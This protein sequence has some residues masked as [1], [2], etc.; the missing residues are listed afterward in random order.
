MLSLEQNERLAHVGP[1]TPMGILMRR[2]WHLVAAT[3]QLENHPVKEVTLLGESLVLFRDLRGRLGL[4]AE[5]CPHRGA[6]LA[7]GIIED[8]GLRC[9]YHGWLYDARGRCLDQPLEPPGDASKDGIT[10]VAYPVQELAGL[11]FAYLG[12][13]PVPLLPRYNVLAW[14]N[15]ARQTEGCLIPCNWLQVM[16]NLMDPMHVE[17]LHRHY[18]AYVL[19]RQGGPRLQEFLAHYAPAPMKKFGFDLFEHGIIERHV[20]GTEGDYSWKTGTPTFFPTT[21]VL[22]SSP[23]TG[24]V[25]FVVPIDDTHTWFVEHVANRPGA[26]PPTQESNP[27]HDVPGVDADGK[28]ITDTANGQDYLA[29]VTQGDIAQREVERLATSDLGIILYRQLLVDQM[30]QVECGRDPINVHRNVSQNRIIELPSPKQVSAHAPVG[31]SA[32]QR[33]RAR[34][35]QRD[36]VRQSLSERVEPAGDR[37]GPG[38]PGNRPAVAAGHYEVVV[39]PLAS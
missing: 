6:S 33:K 5:A 31:Q 38:T 32:R 17:C 16:E 22:G 9:S 11:I 3:A 35:R 28:F 2:Y 10:T 25:I 12:P 7:Y 19:E 4:L 36:M 23:R 13:R 34:H 39:R 20:T 30:E 14:K 1:G 21:S 15:V 8:E 27:F 37:L 18:F 26:A 29:A 24:S